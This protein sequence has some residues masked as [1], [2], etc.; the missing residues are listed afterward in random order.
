MLTA[1]Q[2]LKFQK[3]YRFISIL[4]GYLA[5]EWI[6]TSWIMFRCQFLGE[7]IPFFLFEKQNISL[8]ISVTGKVT[9]TEALR[10]SSCS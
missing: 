8:T 6:L 4:F 9:R 2:Q 1:E 5:F 7:K 10:F 3:K